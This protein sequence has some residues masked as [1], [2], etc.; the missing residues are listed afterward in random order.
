[1]HADVHEHTQGSEIQRID[2]CVHFSDIDECVNTYHGCHHDCMNT[3]GS[4][5]CTC[6]D[7]Y[8]L[9]EDDDRSCE[10]TVCVQLCM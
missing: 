1:M 5:I 3:I 9:S 4:Y 2:L 7:G 8:L 10:G 6:Y